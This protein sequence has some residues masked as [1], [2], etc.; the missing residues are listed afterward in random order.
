MSDR[1]KMIQNAL[2]VSDSVSFALIS[3][4]AVICYIVCATWKVKKILKGVTSIIRVKCYYNMILNYVSFVYSDNS[5][6]IMG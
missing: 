5:V 6:S 3:D 2:K 4:S 1:L